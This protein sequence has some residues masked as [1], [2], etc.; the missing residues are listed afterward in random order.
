MKRASY[1]AAVQW[2]AFND[3]PGDKNLESIAGYISTLLVVD[4]FDVKADKVAKDI[5]RQRKKAK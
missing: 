1:R 4:I 2:I 3:E 5:L